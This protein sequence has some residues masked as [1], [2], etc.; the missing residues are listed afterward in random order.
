MVV[1]FAILSNDTHMFQRCMGSR[2]MRSVTSTHALLVCGDIQGF[3]GHV[4]IQCYSNNITWL[5][6]MQPH[7]VAVDI[8]WQDV[9]WNKTSH[10]QLHLWIQQKHRV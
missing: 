8:V 2:L 3:L 10:T 7:M 6:K 1:R 4:V 5:Y 9:M